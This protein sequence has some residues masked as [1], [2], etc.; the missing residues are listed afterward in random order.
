M[1]DH[2][3]DV[4][5]YGII[6]IEIHVVWVVVR[7]DDHC[8]QYIAKLIGTI[9]GNIVLILRSVLTRLR[10]KVGAYGE[11]I[12]GKIASCIGRNPAWEIICIWENEKYPD[13]D[14]CKIESGK[15]RGH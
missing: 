4:R 9:S 15:D 13:G 12:E 7:R 8:M 5:V 2:E 6:K 11:A 10:A 14:A 3:I 1:G